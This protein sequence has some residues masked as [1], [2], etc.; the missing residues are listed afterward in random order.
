MIPVT[1]APHP[2]PERFEQTVREPGLGA[3]AE[4]VGDEATRL[5]P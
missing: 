4:L 3:L 1:P 5:E 2:D